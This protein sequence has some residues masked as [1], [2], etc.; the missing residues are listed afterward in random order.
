VQLS[1]IAKVVLSLSL[2]IPCLCILAQDVHPIYKDKNLLIK[3]NPISGSRKS[4][5]LFSEMNKLGSYRF[6]C[7]PQDPEMNIIAYTIFGK[8]MPIAQC[9]E[10]MSSVYRFRWE[11]EVKNQKTYFVFK[12]N[13]NNIEKTYG[14]STPEEENIFREGKKLIQNLKNAS[15]AVRSQLFT[16][17]VKFQQLPMSVQKSVRYMIEQ[18]GEEEKRKAGM[19]ITQSI[20]DESIIRVSQ[21]ESRNFDRYSLSFTYSEGGASFRFNSVEDFIKST[22]S[23]T[24]MKSGSLFISKSVDVKKE[25]AKIAFLD[26]IDISCT[27]KRKRLWQVMQ[28]ISDRYDL[29]IFMDSKDWHIKTAD[30]DVRNMPLGKFMHYLQSKYPGIHWEALPGQMLIVRSPQNPIVRPENGQHN[31]NF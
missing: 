10:G 4:T 29:D 31:G 3:M 8:D 20:I 23:K 2:L 9:M 21:K 5:S 15:P 24:D 17:G 6:K 16:R 30:V 27:A 28:D 13:V 7:D 22:K 18:F 1:S 25:K 26:S 14:A 11:K 19:E 12:E